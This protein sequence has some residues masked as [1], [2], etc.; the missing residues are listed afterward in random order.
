MMNAEINSQRN[1]SIQNSEDKW[2]PQL[3]EYQNMLGLTQKGIEVLTGRKE[4]GRTRTKTAPKRA[5]DTR[6][7]VREGDEFLRQL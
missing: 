1:S 3:A 7:V 4:R 2:T 6:I 5:V